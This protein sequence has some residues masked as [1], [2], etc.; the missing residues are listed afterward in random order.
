MVEKLND[1]LFKSDLDKMQQRSIVSIGGGINLRPQSFKQIK[2]NYNSKIIDNIK[3]KRN[4]FIISANIIDGDGF[5]GNVI[6]DKISNVNDM[7]SYID[8]TMFDY[9]YEKTISKDK[10]YIR[11]LR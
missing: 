6:G 8:Y 2:R 3:T 5:I 10:T 1:I 7:P 9:G 11:Y 4:K